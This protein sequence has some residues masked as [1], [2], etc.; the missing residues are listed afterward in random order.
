MAGGLA[1]SHVRAFV[2][3][4]VVRSRKV[5]WYS[6]R[7]NVTRR[8][9]FFLLL[10]MDTTIFCACVQ[11]VDANF[12][13]EHAAHAARGVASERNEHG[14]CGGARRWNR[15]A[16]A[17]AW[18]DRTAASRAFVL[19]SLARPCL[20]PPLSPLPPRATLHTPPH[21]PP[22]TT[23]QP[24]M[25]LIKRTFQPSVIRRKHKHGFR[26]RNSTVGGR[27]VIAR[28]KAKGRARISA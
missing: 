19:P 18:R 15:C 7:G 21:P 1:R 2:H 3:R 6:K 16:I 14:V 8:A 13:H 23:N 9:G 10:V 20:H 11:H 25:F 27:R 4:R 26:L 12:A 24:G 17:D 5:L 22:R 28:R